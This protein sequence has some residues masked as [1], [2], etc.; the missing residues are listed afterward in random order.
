MSA[1][2]QDSRLALPSVDGPK[3]LP[4]HFQRDQDIEFVKKLGHGCHSEVFH[5]KIDG[6]EYAL[7]VVG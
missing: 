3:M 4:F 6:K 7:K 2:S 1:E 5:V